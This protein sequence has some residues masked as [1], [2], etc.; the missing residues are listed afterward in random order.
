MPRLLRKGDLKEYGRKYF[1]KRRI[2]EPTTPILG[3]FSHIIHIFIVQSWFG[4]DSKDGCKTSNSQAFHK[5][6]FFPR[7]DPK[8]KKKT[9]RKN[10][11]KPLVMYV[12]RDQ[13]HV[14]H[15]HARPHQLKQPTFPSPILKHTKKKKNNHH[16]QRTLPQKK[17]YP[18][19]SQSKLASHP[20]PPLNVCHSPLAAVS[21][22]GSS[23]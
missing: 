18:R 4:L 5:K 12:S 22:S 21:K 3:K 13:R 14:L 7:P 23:F 17:K 19:L 2:S 15:H 20:F 10:K 6:Q 11:K 8:K 1:P 16:P 9:H